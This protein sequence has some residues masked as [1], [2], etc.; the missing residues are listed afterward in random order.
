MPSTEPSPYTYDS[1]GSCRDGENG[2]A[3]KNSSK[4]NKQS[5]KVQ[6]NRG[7]LS[8]MSRTMSPIGTVTVSTTLPTYAHQ[9][10]KADDFS[11]R[12]IDDD[13]RA[14][15]VP[16]GTKKKKNHKKG[17][18]RRTAE[19]KVLD[20]DKMCGVFLEGSERQ[21]TRALSCKA[22]A[23]KLKR[24]VVGRTR[25]FDE[26]L[27]DALRAS[28]LIANAKAEEKE[29]QSL[30]I[31]IKLGTKAT[32][33]LVKQRNSHVPLPMPLSLAAVSARS[34][35]FSAAMVSANN[36]AALM[37]MK[38]KRKRD[39][40]FVLRE[41]PAP[42]AV[43]SYGARSLHGRHGFAWRS[44]TRLLESLIAFTNKCTS[45]VFSF[46]VVLLV[47]SLSGRF[48]FRAG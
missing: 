29:R 17:G 33:V 48:S 25:S 6:Q 5:Q 4:S 11:S 18:A 46:T 24:A 34:P 2:N 22:H 27:A 30:N 28:T 1:K 39:M 36:T 13:D 8:N 40:D 9:Q 31:R 37:K 16:K 47:V 44:S 10:N 43:C 23:V 38:K 32:S 41:S 20:L 45:L 3:T 19:P 15:G 42:I 14:L 7:K 35:Q 12:V 26:H 21:C